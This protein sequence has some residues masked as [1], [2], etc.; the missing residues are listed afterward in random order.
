MN[1]YGEAAIAIAD[2]IV[3]QLLEEYEITPRETASPG[4]D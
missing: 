2:R 1:V 4:G 3:A